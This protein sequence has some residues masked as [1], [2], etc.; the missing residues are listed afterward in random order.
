MVKLVLMYRGKIE[1]TFNTEIEKPKKKEV[2]TI[3]DIDNNYVNYTVEE[4]Q[5]FFDRF[6]EFQYL[7]VTAI[8]KY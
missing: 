1:S 3:V 2:I 4:I 7:M 6:G 8:R 5:Y